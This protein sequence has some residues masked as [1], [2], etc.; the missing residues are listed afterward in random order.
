M[1]PPDL[2]LNSD[3]DPGSQ[4]NADPDP[5]QTLPSLEVEFFFLKNILYLGNRS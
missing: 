5:G 1:D 2:F 3:P 4:T